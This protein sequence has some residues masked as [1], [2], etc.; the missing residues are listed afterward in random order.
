MDVKYFDKTRKK[1]ELLLE[2]RRFTNVSNNSLMV[3]NTA[4]SEK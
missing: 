3:L 4:E 1:H 2:F